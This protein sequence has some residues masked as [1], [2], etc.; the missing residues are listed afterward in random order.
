MVFYGRVEEVERL[1][2]VLTE[3]GQRTAVVY[4]RR[5]V[6]KSALVKQ[7][8]R[9][10]GGR[11]IYYECKQT[12]E[13]YNVERLSF[14]LSELFTLPPLAFRGMEEILRFIFEKSIDENTVLCLDEYPYLRESVHG[15]DE[16]LKSLLEEYRDRSNLKLILCGSAID[17]LRSLSEKGKPLYERV[18]LGMLVAPM[19]YYDSALFYPSFSEEDKVKL[20]SVFGGIPYYN[21]WIRPE[22][23]AEENILELIVSEGS[24]LENEVSM[25][26]KSE[27]TK[28][29]N[30]NEVFD[31]LS[32]GYS[33][34]SE[35]L[36][37]SNVSSS[38]TLSDTL[39]KL[40]K[41]AIVAKRASGSAPKNRKKAGY[42][43]SDPLFMFYYRYLF[44]Y[45]SQRAFMDERAFYERYIKEDFEKTFV[46]MVLEQILCQYLIRK[47]NAKAESSDATAGKTVGN[48]DVLAMNEDGYL[49]YQAEHEDAE[50]IQ[51]AAAEEVERAQ[52]EGVLS[53]SHFEEIDGKKL[54][55]LDVKELYR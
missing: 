17:T 20:Y 21:R 28:L 36:S 39:D 51:K 4:G 45:S 43:I 16:L 11:C 10:R 5:R 38:P 3:E 23:T 44:R 24:R 34:F 46:P 2:R 33:K 19:D 37:Q 30:V 48:L 15:M 12:S 9:K 25:N 31:A 22:R 50:R 32:C 41:M 7:V 54:L 26:L 14:L 35:L 13:R 27:L 8:L 42:Y 6:G 18:D 1:R 29:I 49:V 40:T 52:K 55:L 53:A 47:S